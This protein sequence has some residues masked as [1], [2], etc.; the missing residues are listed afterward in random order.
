MDA[1]LAATAEWRS[2]AP[3]VGQVVEVWAWLDVELAV[4]TGTE[5]RT[6]EGQ[7]LRYVRHWR[8]RR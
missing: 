3:P 5:W 7:T 4:W 1:R 2:D 6:M 8:E